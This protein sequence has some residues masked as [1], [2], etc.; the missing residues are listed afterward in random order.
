MNTHLTPIEQ[1]KR[2]PAFIVYNEDCGKI[3]QDLC[4]VIQAARDYPK[5]CKCHICGG[6][7]FFA[8]D[9]GW[10]YV[11]YQGRY[12]PSCEKCALKYGPPPGDR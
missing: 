11:A 6:P 9:C 2:L 4:S 7:N 3:G 5:G 12:E 10:F 8:D 1:L